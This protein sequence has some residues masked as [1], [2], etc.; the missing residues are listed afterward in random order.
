MNILKD[1]FKGI[2]EFLGHL[3]VI[4]V[5]ILAYMFAGLV[6]LFV[7]GTVLLIIVTMFVGA[8]LLCVQIWAQLLGGF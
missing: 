8:F 4:L 3:L 2:T 6:A 7:V 1:I 5:T